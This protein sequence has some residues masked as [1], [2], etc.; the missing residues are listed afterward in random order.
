MST[1]TARLNLVSVD[2]FR[3]S[4][5][6]WIYYVPIPKVIH[7]AFGRIEVH[8]EPQ[9]SRGKIHSLLLQFTQHEIPDLK[10]KIF[11][12]PTPQAVRHTIITTDHLLEGSFFSGVWAVGVCRDH[13][14]LLF[15]SYPPD[16]AIGLEIE[17]LTTSISIN[18]KL[19]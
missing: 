6:G 8:L 17:T 10:G 12:I 15:S 7:P 2:H 4:E 9:I 14:G 5:Y 16:T 3:N 1:K 19:K 18:Y 13:G 11:E